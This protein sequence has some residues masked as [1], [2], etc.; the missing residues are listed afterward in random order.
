MRRFGQVA[1]VFAALLVIGGTPGLLSAW[2]RL[3]TGAQSSSRA[4]LSVIGVIPLL[5]A[6]AIASLL[7]VRRK[8]IAA[9]LFD[10]DELGLQID[11][12]GLLQVALVTV[13]FVLITQ[14]ISAIGLQ[15]SLV[16][17]Q[18][19]GFVSSEYSGLRDRWLFLA[20]SMLTAV[21]GLI[22]LAVGLWLVHKSE[23]L[24]RRWSPYQEVE[25]HRGGV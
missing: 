3:S 13:G 1:I 16:L 18:A 11:A 6:V 8:A 23:S 10:D 9:R 21:L 19:M 20:Y 17:G 5:V 2:L 25:D 22:P 7:I 15:V 14:A 4:L 12:R 24:A